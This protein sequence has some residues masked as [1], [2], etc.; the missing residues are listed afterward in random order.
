[1]HRALGRR[2]DAALLTA[3]LTLA[4]A[5]TAI[6]PQDAAAMPSL[7]PLHRV[8]PGPA[9]PRRPTRA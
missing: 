8:P 6:A 9:A 4:G 2:L 7:L 5:V 3:E 1:M